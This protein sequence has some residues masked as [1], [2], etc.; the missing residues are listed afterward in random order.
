MNKTLPLSTLALAL[1]TAFPVHAQV[2]LDPVVITAERTRQ[3]SFDAPAAIILSLEKSN[4]KILSHLD[5]GI[6]AQT[7]C[8]VA[9]NYGLGTCIEDQGTFYPKVLR[10]YAGIPEASDCIISIS[11]GY[12]DPDFP[13]NQLRST[14]EPMEKTVTW[15]GFE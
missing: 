2:E 4:E 8:L 5:I 15:C 9:M 6:M 13:A 10:Q 1:A 7:I 3:A 11:I 12:P 14:R